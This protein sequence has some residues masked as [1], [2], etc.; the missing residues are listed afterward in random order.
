MF[1]KALSSARASEDVTPPNASSNEIPAAPLAPAGVLF[2]GAAFA[3]GPK[4]SSKEKGRDSVVLEIVV[5]AAIGAG[6]NADCPKG[7]ELVLGPAGV[8]GWGAPVLG[9]DR[10]TASNP[11]VLVRCAG[12]AGGNV[13]AAVVVGEE[14]VAALA[15]A[16][17]KSSSKAESKVNCET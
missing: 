16:K 7:E 10:K 4:A 6:G 2:C 11:A 8:A 17:S 12:C 14:H 9:C 1:E 15:A 13:G 3:T 5:V